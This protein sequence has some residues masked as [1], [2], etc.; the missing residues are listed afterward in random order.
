MNMRVALKRLLRWLAISI[1][2]VVVLFGAVAGVVGRHAGYPAPSGPY[3]VGRTTFRWED[4]SRPETMTSREDD[5]R[6]VV[7]HLWYPADTTE[8][9]RPAPYVPDLEAI[10]GALEERSTLERFK[11]FGLRFIRSHAL[12]DPELAQARDRYPVLL[13]SPGNDTNGA[14]YSAVI[15]ELVSHGHVVAAIDHP[16]DVMAARLSDGR[17][18]TF[19]GER[20]PAP[21]ANAAGGEDDHVRFYRE[22]VGVRAED[23]RFVLNRLEAL[24]AA[25]ES[26]FHARLDLAAVGIFGHSVGGVT[27]GTACLLDPRMRACLNMDGLMAGQAYLP[28]ANGVGP[29]QSFML[30]MKAVLP[31]S[32]DRL[33]AWGVSREQWQ[34][35]YAEGES[36]LRAQVRGVES[37]SYRAVIRGATHGSFTDVPLLSPSLRP[38]ETRQKARI[39]QAVRAYTLAFF[40]KQLRDGRAPL[41]EVSAQ[42]YPEV[43]LEVYV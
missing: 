5:H 8:G 1:L 36:R 26:R 29:R 30:L 32:D 21:T 10:R 24:N 22:R 12:A 3:A 17:V 16:Y 38:A 14:F 20:W 9:A 27:A 35:V 28:G 6:E 33:A 18:A 2:F 43:M 37:E 11:L 41:L 19:A 15:E 42:D 40:D 39:M 25:P 23:A 7:V 34:A 13:F 4:A 31:P